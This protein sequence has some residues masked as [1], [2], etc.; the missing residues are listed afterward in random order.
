MSG[1][2]INPILTTNAAALFNVNSNGFVQGDAQD[3]PAVK[4][5]LC[6]GVYDFNAANPIL[7]GM[8]ILETI[9]ALT[10][11]GPGKANVGAYILNAIATG[12]YA[13]QIN[14]FSVFNQAFGGITTPQ[15]NAPTY[16]PGQSVN[17]YRA[18]S[19][20]RI[21]VRA[22]N[23]LIATI[24]GGQPVNG[25][26]CSWDYTG[27]QLDVYDGTNQFPFRILRVSPAGNN[28]TANYNAGAGTANWVTNEN[29]A[30]IQ[31]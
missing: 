24:T 22:S 30:L 23:A 8:P 1:I 18:G 10:G 26:P 21:P 5:A 17:Y 16:Q 15:S 4:F 31:L 27:N 11:L 28:L 29:V 2:S 14:G 6:Q 9:P 20:A 25:I 19:G 13:H 12:T 7:G 3:D